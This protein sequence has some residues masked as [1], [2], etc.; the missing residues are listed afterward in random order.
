MHGF[1]QNIESLTNDNTYF[2]S[3]L[4]TGKHL[5]LV[6]M[7]ILPHDDIGEETHED[8]DQFFRIESGSGQVWIDGH[9]TNIKENDGI[10]VPAGSRH[11][12]VNNGNIAL[13]LYTLYAPPEHKDKILRK[14]KEDSTIQPE[15]FDGTTTEI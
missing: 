10:I 11:N 5:Q 4:Y 3:V 14:T 9:F 1:I 7:S 2:R 13:S 8:H 15:H 6:L 12:I